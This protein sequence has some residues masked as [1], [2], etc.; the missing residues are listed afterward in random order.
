MS[1]FSRVPLPEIVSYY[2]EMFLFLKFTTLLLS[3][4]NILL[5]FGS[6]KIMHHNP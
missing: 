6:I 4:F 3:V 2:W 5:P 1:E